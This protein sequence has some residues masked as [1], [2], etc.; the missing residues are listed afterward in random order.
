[1]A[2]EHIAPPALASA[3]S[4]HYD[5]LREAGRG[6]SATVYLAHDLKH[7]RHVAIKVLNADVGDVSGD[8]FLLE[9]RLSAGM[10]HP[11]I[12]PTY[13]S[14]IAADRLYFVMPF[15]DG[16]TLRERL[17]AS[18]NIPLLEA[19]SIVRDI[20]IA[21]AHAHDLGVVHRDVKPENILFY[22]GVACLADFGIAKAIEQMHPLLTAQGTFV[23]T[24]AYMSPEQYAAIG[25]DGRTDVYSLSC[26]LYEMLAGARL[27]GGNTPNSVLA[28]RGV[29][30]PLPATSSWPAR[31]QLLLDTGLAADPEQRFPSVRAF[32]EAITEA[33]HGI[34][35]PPR[36]SIPRRAIG[37][38]RRRKL[39]TALGAVAILGFAGLAWGTLAR[40][41]EVGL[42]RQQGTDRTASS[43]FEAGTAAIGAWRIPDAIAAFD[44]ADTTSPATRLWQAQSLALAGR[45]D[46]DE[47]RVAALRLRETLR[48][49]RGRDS[50]LAEGLI[51]FASGTPS[52]ACTAYRQLIARDSLDALAWFG[53]ADCQRTDSSVVRDATSPSGW[54]FSS[55]FRGAASAY[56]RVVGLNPNAHAAIPFAYLTRLL[57]VNAASIRIGRAAGPS[58]GMFAAYPALIADT[59]GFVPYP[60]NIFGSIARA[61]ISPTQPDALERN[62]DA[63]LEFARHWTVAIPAS[64]DSWEAVSLVRENRGELSDDSSGAGG[65]IRRARRLSTDSLK[66]TQLAAAQIRLSI[67][68]GDFARARS[69]ADSMLEASNATS[70]SPKVAE[71]LAGI[72]ALTGRIE[73]TSRF[74]SI[75]PTSGFAPMGVAPAL[76][77]SALQFTARAAPGVCDDSVR[78]LRADFERVLDSYSTPSRK[79]QL[80]QAMIWQ[81][82]ALAFPCLRGESI[83]GLAA[84]SPLDRAQ[85]AFAAGNF[86]RTRALL[87]SLS[88]MRDGYRPGDISLDHTVQEAWLRANIGDTVVAAHQLDLVLDALPTLGVQAVLEPAQSAAVGRAMA[89]RADLAFARRDKTTSRRW[90]TAVVELWK[91]AD[92]ALAPTIA[93]MRGIAGR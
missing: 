50:L 27:F 83:R 85:W 44:A 76:A 89:L 43:S 70:G 57:P 68:R 79:D 52:S 22:H 71:V 81:G 18:P 60:L 14:G 3:F 32:V 7:D 45:L 6:G 54:R 42:A 69:I 66:Q 35:H 8:R 23:G 15:V 47:F 72:S 90:A 93:R 36:V 16:G 13:D 53:L 46:R 25:V 40:E 10:Q 11:H 34:E 41:N 91:N 48:T 33:I 82:A 17:D 28:A 78:T 26:V 59:L 61:T 5:L 92:P 1:M 74:A 62:R 29:P 87:D 73:H 55:S 4:G 58:G 64:A 67:K 84:N 9:I 21:L 80:R 86:P 39:A 88:G 75:A 37:V 51:A 31:V 63:L 2:G 19:L 56:M 49:L 77:I 30:R 24:P 20:G 12:L 65:A 38:V